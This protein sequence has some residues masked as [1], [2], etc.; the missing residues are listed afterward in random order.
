[1]LTDLYRQSFPTVKELLGLH[2]STV[3]S[4]VLVRFF[5]F[6]QHIYL[7]SYRSMVLIISPIFLIILKSCFNQTYAYMHLCMHTQRG[8]LQIKG[9]EKST[10][11]RPMSCSGERLLLPLYRFANLVWHWK[12]KAVRQTTWEWT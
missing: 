11:V 1:M 7:H 12:T 9:E 5:C 4:L 10:F 6:L 3:E 2:I 8:N